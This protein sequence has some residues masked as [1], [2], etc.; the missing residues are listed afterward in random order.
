LATLFNLSLLTLAAFGAGLGIWAICWA[1]LS[2]K[3]S[4]A[5]RGRQLF[6]LTLLGFGVASLVAAG[7][8]AD[9]LAPLGLCAGLLVVGM[10]WEAPPQRQP[11]E[12]LREFFPDSS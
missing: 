10:V 9:A 1:R 8:H 2:R 6:V 12:L 3:P 5:A 7:C 11:A 4:R